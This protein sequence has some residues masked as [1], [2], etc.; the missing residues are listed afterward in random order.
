MEVDYANIYYNDL[1]SPDIDRCRSAAVKTKNAIIGSNR[2]KLEIVNARV[3]E[4]LATILCD[5][6]SDETLKCEITAIIGSIARIPEGAAAIIDSNALPALLCQLVSHSQKL[7][8]WSLNAIETLLIS[9]SRSLEVIAAKVVESELSLQL[10]DLLRSTPS[11]QIATSSVLT[12]L[13]EVKILQE[14]FVSE[15]LIQALFP[16]LCS[17]YSDVVLAGLDCLSSLLK[18]QARTAVILVSAEVGGKPFL[19]HLEIL[20][21]KDN[22]YPIQ[23]AASKIITYLHRP[24]SLSSSEPIVKLKVIP[25]LVRLCHCDRTIEERVEAARTLSY[26]IESDPELQ[27]IAAI[28]DHSISHLA[29]YLKVPV[30]D[31]AKGCGRY[32]NVGPRTN[33][34][35]VQNELRDA[36][37]RAFASLADSDEEIRKRVLETEGLMP[38]L[39]SALNE[40]CRELHISA[41]RCLLSISRSVQQLRTT[42][43]DHSVW[44]P[45]LNLMITGDEGVQKAASGILCNLLLEF[46][47]SKEP[48]LDKGA[49][50]LLGRLTASSDPTLRLNG[51]WALMNISFQGDLR[52]KSAVLQ[53]LGQDQIFQLL[54][55]TE[56]AVQLKTL[57]LMR[58]LLSQYSHIDHIMS[59]HGNQIMQ[60]VVMVLEGDFTLEVKEQGLCVLSNVA[61][62]DSAKD[63]IITNQ[64]VLKKIIDYVGHFDVRLQLAAAECIGNLLRV[65]DIG[66]NDRRQELREFGAERVIRNV[67]ETTTDSILRDKLQ[68]ALQKLIY[69]E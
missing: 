64:D 39:M 56:Q 11:N 51:V 61:D 63:F 49:S 34:L 24:G 67:I 25:T 2:Q 17:A 5:E 4:R 18:Y 68:F 14:R 23:L 62:G 41:L 27:S 28:C 65:T 43:Q 44:R 36:A 40:G 15:G 69:A 29:Q 33:P 57:A 26:L 10:I 35:K 8:S 55:D 19:E 12:I 9:E 42:F 54:C 7:M 48:L 3:I 16:L 20:L 22:P 21:Y 32:V 52:V 53:S 38:S 37:F 46:S 30:F 66:Y 6:S 13:C 59:Q 45:V 50:S 58:N 1:F 31:M 47:P 60:A